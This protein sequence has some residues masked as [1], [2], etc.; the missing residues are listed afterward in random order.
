[1]REPDFKLVIA[2]RP[3]TPAGGERAP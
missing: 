1:V 3:P 2:R